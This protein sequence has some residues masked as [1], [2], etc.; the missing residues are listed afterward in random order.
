MPSIIAERA[1][2]FTEAYSVF[3]TTAVESSAVDHAHLS[4]NLFI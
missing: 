4:S 2:L 3:V 1:Y